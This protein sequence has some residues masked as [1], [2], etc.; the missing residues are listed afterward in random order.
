MFIM[1]LALTKEINYFNPI[2]ETRNV[3]IEWGKNDPK[4]FPIFTAISPVEFYDLL[5]NHKVAALC[6]LI[7]EAVL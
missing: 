7:I 4:L 1:A 5:Y 6:F 3:A 2:A